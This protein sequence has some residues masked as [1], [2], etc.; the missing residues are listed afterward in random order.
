MAKVSL[1][2]VGKSYGNVHISKNINLE[3]EEGEF[4][5]F[6]GPSGCGKS[7]LLRMIAGLEDITT[8]ELYIGDKLMNDV[9]PS[10]RGIGMVF[11]SYALYPHLDVAENMS[12]GL[13]LAGVSKAERTQRVNQVAEI[14]QLAHLLD[15]KPKALSGGQRQRVAI[16]RTIVSQPEVFLL[17]EP[18]SNL[19]AALRVQ[20]RVEI[21][22]LHKRLN[23]TMIYVTHDQV[24]A[25]TLADKIVVLNAG[26]IAQVGKPLELY[27]YPA[28]RFVAS[29]I[30]SPKMN[31]LPVKIT[32][33]EPAKVQIELPNAEHHNFWIPVS[34][35]RVKAGEI[36]SLGIRPEHL[37]PADK[38]PI[39]LRGIVQAVELLGSETQI[40]LEIPEIKQP[41]LIYRQNDVL[42]AKEGETMDI[43]IVPERCHLFREDG[44]ACQRLFTEK[45]V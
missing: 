9:E 25:M 15:R 6:V 23:R 24:E 45:G 32:D 5:V 33:V 2:N 31:F 40:H 29:F 13:K 3:I 42:L 28:N 21:S 37:V 22:K 11:Q 27:H 35:E 16:G 8:G 1:H 4:V 26:G 41:T 36:L 19:D 12:F 43:G 20:M 10:K 18:L 14:L 30:G 39:S 7:T 34:G 38:A 44:T 17:D